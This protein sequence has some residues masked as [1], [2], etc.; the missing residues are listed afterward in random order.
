MKHLTISLWVCAALA[1]GA[2]AQE[3]APGPPPAAAE[4]WEQL[5]AQ[6]R[7]LRQKAKQMRGD[8]QAVHDA[9]AKACWEKFLV[10]GCQQDAKVELRKVERAAQQVDLEAL[11][12]EK[13]VA[14][15][16]RELQRAKKLERQQQRD[17]KAA[18]KAEQLRLEDEKRQAQEAARPPAA[19]R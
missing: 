10:S 14:A 19:G 1:G 18:R 16:E 2:M 11:A 15:H 12:F 13:R 9:T 4:D 7:E 6:A 17:A 8:A 5:R 3:A